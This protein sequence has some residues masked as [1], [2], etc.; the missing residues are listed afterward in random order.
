MA[1]SSLIPGLTAEIVG[2]HILPKVVEPLVEPY[3]RGD[4]VRRCEGRAKFFTLIC[5]YKYM[6]VNKAWR[7]YFGMGEVY[8]ALRLSLWDVDICIGHHF[9]GV[10]GT[11]ELD[12]L[13][14][15]FRINHFIFSHTQRIAIPIRWQVQHA[16]LNDI[17]IMEL[18]YLR[19]KLVENRE[20]WIQVDGRS[21]EHRRC[22]NYWI[23]PSE[24]LLP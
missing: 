14:R 3:H 9:R 15:A 7:E 17:W 20:H 24:R 23:C 4:Y 21:C 2:E 13:L 8:N 19:D 1:P 12:E 11:L 5:I 22:T 6:G 10:R 16:R 18:E